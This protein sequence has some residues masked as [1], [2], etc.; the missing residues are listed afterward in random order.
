M[1]FVFYFDFAE[2]EHFSRARS[3]VRRIASMRKFNSHDRMLALIESLNI[4]ID[5]NFL[6]YTLTA[7]ESIQNPLRTVF[8][9]IFHIFQVAKII[10]C[11]MQ[12]TWIVWFN[13]K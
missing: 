6:N 4:R 12:E 1:V 11:Y 10:L 3:A 13:A 7:S 2:I 8:K 9:Q 5:V